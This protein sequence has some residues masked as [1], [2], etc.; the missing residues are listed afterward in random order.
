MSNTTHPAQ[1][2]AAQ[3][4]ATTEL[5]EQ[6]LLSVDDLKSLT[7]MRR[8]APQWRAVIDETSSLKKKM[9]LVPQQLD[10]E[11]YLSPGAT[12]LHRRPR[13]TDAAAASADGEIIYKSATPN[14]L[15]FLHDSR[16]PIWASRYHASWI[17]QPLF[18]QEQAKPSLLRTRGVFLKM[19]A[20]QPPVPVMYLR[21][22]NGDNELRNYRC[23]VERIKNSKGVKVGDVL[24]ALSRMPKSQETIVVVE[25]VMF[26]QEDAS[27]ID[28]EPWYGF[29]YYE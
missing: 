8:V 5:L 13:T 29:R 28:V 23:L 9:W 4:F 15:L 17:S 18:I 7:A 10:H 19:F 27:E 14:P 25:E 16:R 20:T 26:P 21:V 22:R 6:M 12:H 11:W 24:R 2:A 1:S 3:V